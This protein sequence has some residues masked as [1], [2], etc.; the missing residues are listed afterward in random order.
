MNF[1]DAEAIGQM[2]D[3]HWNLRMNDMTADLW[4]QTLL[5][6]DPQEATKVV[7]YLAQKMHH[8]P[9]ISDF[10]EVMR[11]MYGRQR[12]VPDIVDLPEYKRGIEAPEWVWVWSWARWKRDPV[13]KRPFPQQA[14]HVDTT[15]LLTEEE[16]EALLAEW[17]EAG[18]PKAASP[19]P[20]AMGVS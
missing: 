3:G 2:I 1:H 9:K 14:G 20:L 4:M 13:E 15:E 5:P 6:E 7:A 17:L 16:Y 11:M 10:K 18:S 8:P 19:L 12:E